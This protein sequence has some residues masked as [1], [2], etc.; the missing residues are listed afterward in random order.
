VRVSKTFVCARVR[1]V[2][3]RVHARERFQQVCRLL[4]ALHVEAPPRKEVFVR[5]ADAVEA[6]TVLP[7]SPHCTGTYSPTA[8]ARY[9]RAPPTALRLLRAG[10]PRIE[11][12]RDRGPSGDADVVGQAAACVRAC[13]LEIGV[14]NYTWLTVLVAS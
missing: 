5:A 9:A 7:S 3:A 13:V 10:A 1:V 6:A 11:V 8:A 2:C 4:H 12:V 14:S